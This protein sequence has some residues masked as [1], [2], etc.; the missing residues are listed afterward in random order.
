MPMAAVRSHAAH[1]HLHPVVGAGAHRLLR[2]GHEG[3][4]IFVMHERKQAAALLGAVHAFPERR[5]QAPVRFVAP[6]QAQIAVGIRVQRHRADDAGKHAVADGVL[7]QQIPEIE[8]GTARILQSALLV[9]NFR[10]VGQQ[11]LERRRL[12]RARVVVALRV[13]A[14][15]VQK[16]VHLLARL[17]AFG[18]DGQVQ[19]ARHA[20]DR[21]HDVL[22]APVVA[23][24]EAHVD[25]QHVD[26]DVLQHVERRVAAAEVVHEHGEAALGQLVE[27][28]HDAIGAFRIGALGDLHL[29]ERRF[30]A[31]AL[32]ERMQ[33][34]GHVHEV[35]VGARHVHRHGNGLHSF[36]DEAPDPRGGL[37]P[38]AQVE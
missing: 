28:G 36:V 17:H 12:H 2:R 35:D 34:G 11:R 7:M 5:Y 4:P 24:E 37:L 15:H 18:D 32:H 20:D 27:R 29:D 6:N 13:R 22:A 19:P 23:V 31:V 16:E 9:L 3:V 8:D 25:L 26:V 33:F 10:T 21:F 30:D 38:H 1:D 14:P